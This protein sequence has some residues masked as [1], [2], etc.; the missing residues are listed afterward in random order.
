MLSFDPIEEARRNWDK[1]GWGAATAMVAATSITRAH[2]IV[3]GRIN[4]ALAP[5][6]LTFSR[7]EVLAL[8]HFS[9]QGALPMGKIGA[10]LQVHPTSVTSLVDRLAGD[11]LVERRPHPTDRRTTLVQ[12]SEQ[13]ASVV[14]QA[15]QDLARIDFGL[16]ELSDASLNEIASNIE[17]FR[18]EA[19]DW[20]LKL[21]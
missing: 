13:G 14:D 20:N 5:Y 8:V 18:R 11:G 16:A 2:Q 3:L 9:R 1:H 10:R 15:A 7:F 4:A 21:K 19:G 6:G 17:T 12:L